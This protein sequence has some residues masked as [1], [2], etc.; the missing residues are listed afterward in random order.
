[1]TTKRNNYELTTNSMLKSGAALD[2]G[3]LKSIKA[4]NVAFDKYLKERSVSYA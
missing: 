2:G 1:M 3:Y 4:E